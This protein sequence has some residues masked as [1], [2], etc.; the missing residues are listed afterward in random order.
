MPILADPRNAAREEIRRRL[1]STD[2]GN[3]QHL[4]IMHGAVPCVTRAAQCMSQH[5]TT[6]LKGSLACSLSPGVHHERM[7]ICGRCH[8]ATRRRAEGLLATADVACR[9]NTGA[10]A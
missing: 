8:R 4:Y 10:G 6:A 3:R 1:Q 2:C 7:M 9:A 5:D